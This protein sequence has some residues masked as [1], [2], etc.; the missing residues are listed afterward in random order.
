MI[1]LNGEVFGHSQVLEPSYFKYGKK[2][3]KIAWKFQAGT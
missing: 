1:K 2:M 3:Q